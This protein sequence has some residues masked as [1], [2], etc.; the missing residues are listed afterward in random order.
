MSS[1]A[2]RLGL[3]GTLSVSLAACASNAY[4]DVSPPDDSEVVYEGSYEPLPEQPVQVPAGA[5]VAYCVDEESHTDDGSYEVAD[6]SL[7]EVEYEDTYGSV[8]YW[9]YGGTVTGSRVA[10]GSTV[11]P[12]H[13]DVV[14]SSGGP[15]TRGGF[16]NRSASG[17]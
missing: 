12:R 8:Y 14:T 17:S 15:V 11:T 10:G 2:V 4:E 7:C 16:G 5:V 3:L 9:Y 13:A 6:D 1:R